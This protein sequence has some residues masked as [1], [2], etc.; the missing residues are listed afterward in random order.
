MIKNQTINAYFSVAIKTHIW[1]GNEDVKQRM[2]F[3]ICAVFC[4]AKHNTS[5][6]P[7]QTLIAKV[8]GPNP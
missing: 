2:A 6:W 4:T 7:N 1:V 8:H 5:S 3:L